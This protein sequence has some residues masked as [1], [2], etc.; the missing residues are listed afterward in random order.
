M[1]LFYTPDLSGNFYT[2][3]EQESKHCIKVLRLN[4]GDIV[5]LID[6]KG[7]FFK[8][9]IT[10]PHYKRCGV[11]IREQ[12]PDPDNRDYKIHIA[13][14][15]TKNIDRIEW[16]LEKACEI[17]IDR[18]TPLLCKRSERKVIK[19][20][21]LEKILISAMKQSFKATLPILDD[22]TPIKEFLEQDNASTKFVAYCDETIEE[23]K[24]LRDQITKGEDILVLIG[25]EG[26]FD[27]DEIELA[28]DKNFIPVTLGNSRLRT[29][30]AALVAC[31]TINIMNQ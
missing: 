9:E 31:D 28:F 26:D 16:F 22:L 27:K 3:N 24:L 30:T 1:Q 2:F 13:V 29:E 12:L 20:E 18:V 6:G 14:A 10:D 21:R 5:Y 11:E 19:K 25:P 7:G 4:S 15:P 8:A 17:G 23:R